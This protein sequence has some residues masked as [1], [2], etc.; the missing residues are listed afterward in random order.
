MIF[1]QEFLLQ[2][3]KEA[4][5]FAEKVAP[6]YKKTV[7]NLLLWEAAHYIFQKRLKGLQ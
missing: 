4:L 3:Y 6:E 2:A 5:E 7:I 1:D